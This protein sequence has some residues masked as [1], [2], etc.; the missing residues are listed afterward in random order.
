M[1]PRPLLRIALALVCPAAALADLS[2]QVNVDPTSGRVPISPYVYGTNQDLPGAAVPGARRYG[3]DRLT[4]YNWETNASN[5]GTDYM[6]ESDNFLVSG[7]PAD[8]QATPAI[9]LTTY[10]D[11][12]LAEGT[13]YTLLTLQLAGY[14][15][16]DENGDVTAAQVAPS[17]R[18]DSVVNNKPGGAYTTT[19]DLTDG[20]V[21]MDELLNL[22]LL[23]YGPASG[24]TGVKGYDLDN[25]P[26]LWPSTHPLLHPAPTTC[27]EIIARDTATAMTT[28]RMDPSAEVFGPVLY[29]TEAYLTFQ[30]APDWAGI[31]S[32]TGDR[33]FIDYYL[34]QMSQ[35]S[36]TAGR[37]LL[38]VLDLHR[39]SDENISGT[40]PDQS[41]TSQTNFSDTA[42]DMD[43]VQ[44]PRVLWD[45]TFV[46]N[47]W[48]QQYYSPFLP[49]IP[50]LQASIAAHYPGTR[51]SFSEYSY[52]GESDI[53]GGIAQAD[54]LGIYGKFGVYMGCVWLLH[55]SPPPLYLAAAFN[56][57]QNYDGKGGAFGA[58]GIAETDSDTVDTSAYAS[59][60]AAGAVHVVVLNKSFTSTANVTF[61]IKG[62][63]AYASGEVYAFDA[64]SPAV[65]ARPPLAASNNQVTYPLPAL[66]AAHFVFPPVLPGSTPTPTPTPMPTPT[67]TPT[68]TPGPSTVRLVNLAT[69]AHVGTGGNLLIPGFVI[70]GGGTETL[71]IRADGP[72]L[73]Q[74]GVTGFL[75]APVLTVFNGSGAA[76]AANTGW[77][78]SPSAAQITSTAAAVGAFA[79]APGS[80]DSAVVLSL[81]AGSYTVQV[82]GLGGT[83]GVALAEVYEVSSTGPRLVNLSTL[84]QVGGGNLLIPGFVIRGSGTEQLL[85]RADGP[86]LSP[87][88]V[89]GFRAQPALSVL[90][91]STVIAANTGWTTAT[92]PA[93]IT[94]TASAVGAF[95]FLPG[96]ADSAQIVNLSAGA[97]TAEVS[98]PSG[99]SGD[100]LAE[101]YEVP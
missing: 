3:G 50:N 41:I 12:S 15:A 33:W 70:R 72:S 98:G 84:A 61:A 51:L 17:S 79:F 58:T 19:P 92:D 86:G 40:G 99:A 11:Q 34:T 32:A 100:A 13:P 101:I 16:A 78:S 88:G 45:P 60:D 2:I 21:S 52:G 56:L 67:P 28:K 14:V 7:L 93:G 73:E 38:D 59:V 25:E 83:T 23:K 63:T 20:V 71:L 68:P 89:T 80:A 75:A 49:W 66:T 94:A 65:T 10:H 69:R 31:A 81:T 24:K 54:V 9:A 91:G 1:T 47:S 30:N 18:W 57:Y 82:S 37:R 48:V 64:S 42:T 36:G 85:V 6:N 87:F 27:A 74:F 76:I 77:T 97:Y 90:S 4:G 46:E 39:Y 22:L 95:P 35:A 8:E 96:S 44:A 55:S 53:S 5:A 26:S 29:G 62:P 43:R